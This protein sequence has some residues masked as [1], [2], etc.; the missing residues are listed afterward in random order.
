[1]IRY[2]TRWDEVRWYDDWWLRGLPWSLMLVLW[3]GCTLGDSDIFFLS[4][5][6]I[7]ALKTAFSRPRFRLLHSLFSSFYSDMIW[8]RLKSEWEKPRVISQEWWL[9]SLKRKK[10]KVLQDMTREDDEKGHVWRPQWESWIMQSSRLSDF[11]FKG[12][13]FPVYIVVIIFTYFNYLPT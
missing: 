10:K 8:H 13:I 4:R 7:L 12:P 9:F 1:M 3:Y 6:L 5:L 2:D 11:F